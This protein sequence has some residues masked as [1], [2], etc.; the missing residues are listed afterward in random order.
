LNS[1]PTPQS[2][3]PYLAGREVLGQQLHQRLVLGLHFTRE[4]GLPY[5]GFPTHA[6]QGCGVVGVRAERRP[7]FEAGAPREA[8]QIDEARQGF[9]HLIRRGRKRKRQRRRSDDTTRWWNVTKGNKVLFNDY[10]MSREIS[11]R[12]IRDYC[13]CLRAVL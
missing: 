13:C 2:T 3:R 12:K 1:R 4:L 10:Q 9:P 5:W 7:V 6:H 8:V 11:S